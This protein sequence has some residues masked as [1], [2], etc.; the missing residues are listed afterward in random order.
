M[1]SV[2]I[3]MKKPT[4]T[5]IGGANGSGKTTLARE[6]VAERA[7]EYLG[8]DDIARELNPTTPEAVAIKAARIFSQRLGDYLERQTSLVVESTLSGFSLRKW[9]EKARDSDYKVRV[10]FVFLDSPE[11]CIQRIAARVAKGGH[12]VPDEDVRRRYIRSNEN[13]WNIY[14]NLADDWSLFHNSEGNL[15]Q[16]VSADRKD[17]II[18]DEER[19][20]KWLKMVKTEN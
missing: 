10:L 19:Y 17:I 16:V 8:A 4:L 20:E 3:S 9:I 1:E 12:N 18:I 7:V 13:F 6:Y 14:K 5:I 11:L 2:L 15:T